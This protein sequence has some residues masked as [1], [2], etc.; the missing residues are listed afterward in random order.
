MVNWYT[1]TLKQLGVPVHLNH[2][3]DAQFVKS[4]DAD[5]VILATGSTPKTFSLGQDEKV[6]TAAQVLM[7][8]KDMATN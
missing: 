6:Y 2:E 4:A 1:Y 5:A 7:K 8:E 3:V